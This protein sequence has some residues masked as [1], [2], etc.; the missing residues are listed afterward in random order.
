MKQ[1]PPRENHESSTGR[2][3]QDAAV[4]AGPAPHPEAAAE[5]SSS[6]DDHL[7][8]A[9]HELFARNGL[10]VPLAD[11]ARAAGVGVATLYRRYKDKD[12]LI[13]DVYRDHMADGEKF[14][15]TANG[16]AE[17]WDGIEYFLRRSTYQLLH[18]RGMRELVLGGY[19]GGAGWARG[20]THEELI[21]ALDAMEAKV[22]AQLELLVT[23][24]KAAK[25]VREDFQQQD[26]LLISAMAQAALPVDHRGTTAVSQRALQLLI[27]GFRPICTSPQATDGMPTED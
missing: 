6:R 5:V 20:S 25:A 22:T 12:I 26:L 27:E 13:L 24:A 11:I 21:A 2:P 3:H 16:F 7:R 8:L 4:P 10:G 19:I 14:A 9:A 23:R 18:D 15:L 1:L 17:P